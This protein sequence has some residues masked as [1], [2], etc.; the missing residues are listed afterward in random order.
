MNEK[1]SFKTTKKEV[2]KTEK[3]GVFLKKLGYGFG[4]KLDILTFFLLGLLGQENVFYGILEQK[5]AFI[6][7]KNKKFQKVEKLRFLQKG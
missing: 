2:Q 7:Y 5:N 4:Q 6:G 3:F 1:K